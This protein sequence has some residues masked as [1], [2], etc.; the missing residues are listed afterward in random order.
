MTYDGQAKAA[1]VGVTVSSV[2]GSVANILTGGA[3][4]RTTAGTYAV[5]ADFVP[6][7]SVN[8]HTLVAQAAGRLGPD[9]IRIRHPRHMRAPRIQHSHPSKPC[10]GRASGEA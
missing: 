4:S 7:D 9:T 5:T 1:R 2:P 6:D 8:H 10:C 3:A